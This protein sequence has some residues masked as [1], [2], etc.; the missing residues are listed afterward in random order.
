MEIL[1]E[2]F[3]EILL[4]LCARIIFWSL[5]FVAV[6]VALILFYLN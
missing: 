6:I 5:A 2:V 3:A 4:Q 1:F